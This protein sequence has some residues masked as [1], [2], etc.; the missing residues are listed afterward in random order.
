MSIIE[1]DKHSGHTT[2]GHEW[3]GIKELN[4]PV[5]RLVIL[6][7][8]GT[9][10]FS[11]GYWYLMPSWPLVD[12][13]FPGQ[14]GVDERAM[15][16][17]KI[18]HADTLKKELWTDRFENTDFDDILYDDELMA[19]VQASGARLFDDN[20]AMCHGRNGTGNLNYP[21]LIDEAWLRT[22]QIFCSVKQSYR[23]TF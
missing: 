8:I 4:T 11:I 13:F 21:S 14:L 3:N 1:R 2:T 16:A 6:C 5:P 12:R 18:A 7:L 23:I 20:C 10:I 17:D 15:L 19:K 22:V 9:F